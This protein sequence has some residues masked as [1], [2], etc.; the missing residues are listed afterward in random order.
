MTAHVVVRCVHGLEW[1][2]ADEVDERLPD[3]DDVRLA[4]REVVFRLPAVHPDLLGLRTADD[5]FLL[6]GE[7]GSRGPAEIGA[8]LLDLP[9]KERVDDVARLRALPAAP[10]V[11][12]VAQVEG[13]RLTR[14]AV[15]HAVGPLL[16]D[17]LGGGY[18]R[19]TAEGRDP[20]EPDLTV[21]VVVRDDA[22]TAAIRLTAR[23]LHRRGYKLDT[24]P[25]TLHPPV[26]AALARLAGPA[27]GQAVLDP[28]CGDGTIPIETALA[29]PG[30]HVTGRDVDA[31]RLHHAARNAER[32]G[33]TATLSRADAGCPAEG[34]R[35]DAVI[36][37]PPWN[38]AV[39]GVGTLRRGLDPAWR[40]LS[41]LI[42]RPG[43]LVALTT[44][45]LDVP[46]ALAAAGF[47]VGLATRVRLA[48]RVCDVVRASPDQVPVLPERLRAWRDRA[49]A[50]GVV[51]ERGF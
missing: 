29:F 46:S 42:A 19:R 34:S 51:T 30:T 23:P 4:R 28:F 43:L 49:I 15:E 25:G 40:R 7:V 8:A 41:D 9:W 17:R 3:T 6:V 33:V 10:L 27:P 44:A 50:E 1:V 21:R 26:A 38:V 45:D 31:Q 11:D 13:R 12:V 24:G 48:G 18:L 37:N 47:Q 35:Y 22:V 32:A 5:A 39:D 20:G 36:T 16:A 14:F 2:C